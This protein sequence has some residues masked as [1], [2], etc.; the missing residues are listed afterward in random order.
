MT[1]T[2]NSTLNIAFFVTFFLYIFSLRIEYYVQY[3]MCTPI[4]IG[5]KGQYLYATVTTRCMYLKFQWLL[6]QFITNYTLICHV[7]YW[8]SNRYHCC[9]CQQVHL[10]PLSQ[11]KLK[12]T[13]HLRHPMNCSGTLQ[14]GH[15][16]GLPVWSRLLKFSL[17]AKSALSWCLCPISANSGL[18]L[19]QLKLILFER[20]EKLIYKM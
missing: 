10:P 11:Q 1:N 18:T 3:K 15:L 14:V 2:R 8:G 20:K 7:A 19:Y 12:V 17:L 6:Q 13:D 16:R 9:Q 5:K 4:W